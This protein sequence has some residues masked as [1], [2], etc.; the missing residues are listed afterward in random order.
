MTIH[1]KR[2]YDDVSRDDGARVLV[3]RLWPRGVSKEDAQLDHWL[4]EIAPSHDLRKQFHGQ[5]GR[6][7]EFVD[8]YRK[9]LDDPSGEAAEQLELIETLA[10]EG[11][12]T[13][14]YAA[15]DREKNNAEALKTILRER[16]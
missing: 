2:I 5:S 16:A 4:K 10:E 6:W 7:Q 12:V 8:A 1:T 3:D 15:K 13:L 11:D 14:L 9:E